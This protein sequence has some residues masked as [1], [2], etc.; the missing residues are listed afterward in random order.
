MHF[1]AIKLNEFY[2]EV[3]NFLKNSSHLKRSQLQT[4]ENI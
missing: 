2:K 4:F 1:R 3:M